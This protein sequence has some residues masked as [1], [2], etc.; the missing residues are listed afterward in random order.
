MICRF[1]IELNESNPSVWREVVIPAAHSLYQLH[2][3]I[4]AAFGW[5]NYH[6]FQFSENGFAHDV[7]YSIPIEE[8]SNEGCKANSHNKTVQKRGR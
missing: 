4:Q 1:R 5:E 6:L 2:K 3:A 7:Y 8:E